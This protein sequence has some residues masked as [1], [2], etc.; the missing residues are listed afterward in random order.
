[1]LGDALLVAPVFDASGSVTYYLPEGR[2]T[3]FFDGQPVTGGRWISETHDY[4]SLPLMVRENTILPLDSDVDAGESERADA[5]E[6]RVYLPVENG[7][8]S[9]ILS[10]KDGK[11]AL[12]IRIAT[13]GGR[14]TF[15]LLAARS[16]SVRFVG[17]VLHAQ[18]I[19]VERQGRDTV[20]TFGPSPSPHHIL[21]GDV[22]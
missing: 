22:G 15:D 6:L 3:R 7:T 19:A 14:I 5:L 17:A 18:G 9:R 4:F 10:D 1:M 13:D 11:V 21:L 16:C 8:C 2:W 12:N 20:L